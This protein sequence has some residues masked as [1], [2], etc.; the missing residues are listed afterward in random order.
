[1]LAEAR[2]RITEGEITLTARRDLLTGQLQARTEIDA[3]AEGRSGRYLITLHL[4]GPLDMGQTTSQRLL[5]DISSDPLAPANWDWA[6]SRPPRGQ[7]TAR[8]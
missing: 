1:M 6:A 2:A 5:I 8:Q 3:T 7:P 4:H